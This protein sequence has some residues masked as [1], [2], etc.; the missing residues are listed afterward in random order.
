MSPAQG[1][2]AAA[3]CAASSSA[4]SSGGQCPGCVSGHKLNRNLVGIIKIAI[5]R[6]KVSQ[7]LQSSSFSNS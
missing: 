4:S 2:S 1:V 7:V 3:A 6:V 5:K